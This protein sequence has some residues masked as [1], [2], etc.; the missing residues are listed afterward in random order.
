MCVCGEAGVKVCVS[1]R[2]PSA[3]TTTCRG[4]RTPKLVFVVDRSLLYPPHTNAPWFTYALR[5]Y[6][7]RSIVNYSTGGDPVQ[8][9]I[10]VYDVK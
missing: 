1:L 4:I 5:L 9:S 10:G 3:F 7:V 6:I 2:V 8:R